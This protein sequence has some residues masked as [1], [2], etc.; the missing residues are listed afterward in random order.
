LGP[1][2]SHVTALA[3]TDAR[4][5]ETHPEVAFETLN[6]GAPLGY[7]KKSFGGMEERRRLLTGAGI[8]LSDLGDSRAVP[9]DDVLDAAACAWTAS[10]IAAGAA[11]SLPSPPEEREG[12]P[13]A[14]WY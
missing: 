6:S 13:V 12:R 7:R 8:D 9:V 11:L 4:F 5:Y 14:I 10:R 3:S 1:R 2:I